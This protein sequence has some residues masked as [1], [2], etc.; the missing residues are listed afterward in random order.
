MKLHNA[1]LGPAVLFALMACCAN[2][3]AGTGSSGPSSSPSR[4]TPAVALNFTIQIDKFI[5]FRIGDGVWPTPGGTVSQVAFALTPSIPGIPTAPAVGSNTLVNWSGAAPNFNVAANG[6]VLPVEVRSNGG[7]V[8]LFATVAS[9]LTS[10]SNIIPMS[11]I[12]VTSSDSTNLP[13]PLIPASG[14]GSAVNVAG[15]GAGT[16]NSLV[17]SRNANWTFGYANSASRFAGNY[18]GQVTFTAT[19][20]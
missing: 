4:T 7:Q 10:G 17:T 9:P 8:S 13:A 14:S 2:S 11:Q 12:T 3:T 18:N 15:G 6:N 1:Q 20:P 16:V 5:F 19:T